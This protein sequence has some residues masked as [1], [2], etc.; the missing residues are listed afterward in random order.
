VCPLVIV[1]GVSTAFTSSFTMCPFTVSAT[2]PMYIDHLG[3]LSDGWPSLVLCHVP[4]LCPRNQ[5]TL[6]TLVV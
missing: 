2:Q 4:S 3:G 6:T 1:A 5:C